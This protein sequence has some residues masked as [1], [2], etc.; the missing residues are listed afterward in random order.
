[1]GNSLENLS[2]ILPE[3]VRN[4]LRSL[5]SAAQTSFGPDLLSLVLFGSAGGSSGR[6]GCGGGCGG[7]GS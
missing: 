2:S 7:C 4:V 6:G 1:M 3:N 5:V